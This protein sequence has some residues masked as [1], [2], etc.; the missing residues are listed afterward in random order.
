MKF[1]IANK[2]PSTPE[3]GWLNWGSCKELTSFYGVKGETSLLLMFLVHIHW[4]VDGKL[5][6]DRWF[7]S[8]GSFGAKFWRSKIKQMMLN[9]A[10]CCSVISVICIIKVNYSG[11]SP[12]AY[13]HPM[14]TV[15]LN[16]EWNAIMRKGGLNYCSANVTREPIQDLVPSSGF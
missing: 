8:N 10:F 9:H 7:K 12:A 13:S 11:Y 15:N 5:Y 2:M 1:L 4:N 3:T 16:R 6:S 14:I